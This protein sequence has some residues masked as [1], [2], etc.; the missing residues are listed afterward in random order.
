MPQ[1][2]RMLKELSAAK[3]IFEGN[4][5]GF[6]ENVTRFWKELLY[7]RRL[8]WFL[9]ILWDILG[10]LGRFG[11][12]FYYRLD[13]SRMLASPSFPEFLLEKF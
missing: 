8:S 9:R 5:A 10:H 2:A 4:Q 3:R 12:C 7:I 6:L 11:T 1:R 13:W